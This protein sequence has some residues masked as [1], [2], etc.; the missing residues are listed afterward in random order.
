MFRSRFL[1]GVAGLSLL[2]GCSTGPSFGLGPEPVAKTGAVVVG[3]EPYAVKAG[4]AVLAQGGNAVDA[5]GDLFCLG[6]D[7]SC[8][9]RSW[10]WRHLPGARRREPAE[11][12]VRFPRAR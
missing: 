1:A 12:R 7:L 11:R 9:C 6:R 3:D 8:C 5:D 2:S 10:R 4:V